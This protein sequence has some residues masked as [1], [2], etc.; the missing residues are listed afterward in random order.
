MGSGHAAKVNV[1]ITRRAST[2][3]PFPHTASS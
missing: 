3:S 1:I 2:S